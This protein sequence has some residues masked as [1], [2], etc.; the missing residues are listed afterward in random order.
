MSEQQRPAGW[1]DD[2]RIRRWIAGARQREIQMVPVT[3]ELFAAA[4]LRPGETVLD[5]GCGTGPTTI[6]A[7]AEVGPSGRVVGT[8][9]APAMVEVARASAAGGESEQV[10]WLVADAETYDFGAAAYDVVISRFGVMFFPDPAAAFGNLARALRR[11]GRLAMA[12]WQTRDR[13]PLFDLPY[14]VA[15]E[16]LDRR[17]LA[18]EPVA[19][20][21][22]QCSLGTVERVR[23]VLE[24]AG[25]RDIVLHPTE[26][27]LHVGGELTAEEAAREA[28]DIGPIRGLLE[29]RP[30]DVREEVRA[31]LAERFAPRYDGVGVVV[32][33]GFMIVTACR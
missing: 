32:D 6:R 26:Q 16:V 4:A 7:A 3:D 29:G 13:V 9:V 11:E 20:D 33:A 1:S 23:S 30:D 12:V 24:P 2:E 27:T 14:Q 21:D 28:L 8:D 17:G 19:I 25:W 22:S 18:Y 5:V 15:A 10:E 31:G